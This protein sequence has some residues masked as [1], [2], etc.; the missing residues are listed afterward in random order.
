MSDSG[1][2]YPIAVAVGG[3]TVTLRPLVAA[4]GAAVLAFA[5]SLPTHDL[6]FLRRDITEPAEVHAWIAAVAAGDLATVLA[7]REGRV[8]GYCVVDRSPLAWMRHVAELRVMVAA[9]MRG[10]GLGRMLTTEAF[11]IASEMGVEKMVAQMT[12][13]QRTAI[14]VFQ[15]LGFDNEAVLHDHVKDRDG[16]SYDLLMLAHAVSEFETSVILEEYG[17]S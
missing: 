15:N 9:E 4:D 12:T 14:A 7:I 2:R 11:R 16:K 8:I 3:E 6:L 17:T 5:G 1:D 10:K 13:D